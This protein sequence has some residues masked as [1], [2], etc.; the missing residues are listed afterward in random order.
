MNNSIKIFPALDAQDDN[1]NCVMKLNFRQ[2]L[3]PLC[4]HIISHSDS[5]FSFP[6]VGCL[7][8]LLLLPDSSQHKLEKL[9]QALLRSQA[10][11]HV[12]LLS[13][14]LRREHIFRK[15]TEAFLSAS[16]ASFHYR[17]VCAHINHICLN[18]KL[19]KF[20]LKSLS[21]LL[22]HFKLFE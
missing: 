21:I 11:I 4:T 19:A 16:T 2:S 8:D 7:V 15:G 9:F 20:E 10:A 14:L 5:L 6:I 13:F 17:S 18:D 3:S 22:C 12:K 1:D